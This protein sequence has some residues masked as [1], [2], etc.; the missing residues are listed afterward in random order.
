MAAITIHGD[1][2]AQENKVC[3]CF[4]CF[5]IYLPLSDRTRCHDLSFFWMLNFKSASSL[6]LL[7]PSKRST[8]SSSSFSTLSS[9]RVVESA[10][11][12]LLIFLPEI[13]ILACDSSSPGFQMMYSAYKLN[14]QGDNIQP[15]C[16]PSSLLNQF[17]VPC[18]VLFL[19]DLYADFSGGRKV[20]LLFPSL[21]R[22]FH[23][24]L[25]YT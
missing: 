24:L 14:K 23:S 5:P 11:M 4:H 22:I 21:L 19:L 1:F 2:W 6:S 9:I 16:T 17:V 18:P 15:W 12:R 25:W 10:Y 8:V 13:L 20:V 3:H 7:P